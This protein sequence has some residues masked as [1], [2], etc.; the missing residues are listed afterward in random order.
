[1]HDFRALFHLALS[2]II[3]AGDCHV[4]ARYETESEQMTKL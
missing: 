4:E 3:L 2:Y 1:M